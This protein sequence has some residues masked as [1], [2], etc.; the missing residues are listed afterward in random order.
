[1]QVSA[2]T[3]SKPLLNQVKTLK[4]TL[5]R[6]YITT[7]DIGLEIAVAKL[8]MGSP[9]KILHKEK[10]PLLARKDGRVY[11]EF[12]EHQAFELCWGWVTER[13]NKVLKDNY[14]L[15]VEPQMSLPSQGNDRMCIILAN[16]FYTI[17]NTL[18]HQ[19]HGPPCIFVPPT[20]WRKAAGALAERKGDMKEQYKANKARSIVRFVELYGQGAL[21]EI[22]GVD[23][24]GGD[25]HDIPEAVLMAYSLS[26]NPLYIED[27]LPC[28]SHHHG[29]FLFPGK[30]VKKEQRFVECKPVGEEGEE[31]GDIEGRTPKQLLAAHR[32]YKDMLLVSKHERKEKKESKK[33]TTLVAGMFPSGGGE[34]ATLKRKGEGGNSFKSASKRPK[35]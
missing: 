28:N 21:D 17:F 12:H 20:W 9:L 16:T 23:L 4:V 11:S 34:G 15:A 1:M 7:L 32:E 3:I 35:R 14:C 24:N 33:L 29:S 30:H 13:W 26:A 19:G 8:D 31:D 18:Y 10:A 5:P 2:S 22:R 6:K 27:N 25:Y